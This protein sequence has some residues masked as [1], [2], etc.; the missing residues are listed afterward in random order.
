MGGRVSLERLGW[1]ILSAGRGKV[2]KAA[3]PPFCKVI[4]TEGRDAGGW[5]RGWESVLYNLELYMEAGGRDVQLNVT[6]LL[7]PETV[8]GKVAATDSKGLTSTTVESE[9]WSL[10]IGGKPFLSSRPAPGLH[11]FILVELSH[12]SSSPENSC[13]TTTG[14]RR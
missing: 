3:A 4:C 5:E 1:Y 13:F 9:E 10:E 7:G 14:G 6:E 2:L 12:L 11:M 8:S